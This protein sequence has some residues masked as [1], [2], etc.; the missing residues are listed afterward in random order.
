[1]A[2]ATSIRFPEELR[3]RIERVPGSTFHAKV[4]DLVVEGLATYGRDRGGPA[5]PFPEVSQ[6]RRQALTAP[7]TLPAATVSVPSGKRTYAPDA[8]P[9]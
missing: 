8:K 3:E 4:L 6:A 1:V 5:D 9:K 2:R 7:R